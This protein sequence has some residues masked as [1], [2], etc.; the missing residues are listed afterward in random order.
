[1]HLIRKIQSEVNILRSIEKKEKE[2]RRTFSPH[3]CLSFCSLPEYRQFHSFYNSLPGSVVVISAGGEIFEANEQFCYSL[4]LK[5]DQ[6]INNSLFVFVHPS[7]LLFLYTSISHLMTSNSSTFRAIHLFPYKGKMLPHV[8][9]ISSIKSE[10]LVVFSVAFTPLIHLGSP[11]C[12]CP[13]EE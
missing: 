2:K 6:V 8:V 7:T 1:M 5:R 13:T 11:I 9:S 12:V 3:T 10:R 4:R